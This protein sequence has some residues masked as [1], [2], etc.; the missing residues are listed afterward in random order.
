MEA[1]AEEFAEVLPNA[2][3]G[4]GVAFLQTVY[5]IPRHAC[6]S[7]PSTSCP[8]PC[9]AIPKPIQASAIRTRLPPEGLQTVIDLVERRAVI[10]LIQIKVR[11]HPCC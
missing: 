2:F 1:V 7:L 11:S 3:A 9:R 4:D 6:R 8:Q 5:K 10:S